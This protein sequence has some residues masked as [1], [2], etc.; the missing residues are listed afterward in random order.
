MATISKDLITGEKPVSEMT[1]I[2]RS[3]YNAHG[4]ELLTHEDACCDTLEKFSGILSI[5]FMNIRSSSGHY[6]A[7]SLLA[8]QTKMLQLIRLNSDCVE[9]LPL[10]NGFVKAISMSEGPQYQAFFIGAN[11]RHKDVP[12]FCVNPWAEK[13]VVSGE[14]ATVSDA[15]VLEMA[16][17]HSI[18]C[19]YEPE[20]RALVPKESYFP[21]VR[22][23]WRELRDPIRATISEVN[24][25]Q[26]TDSTL[27]TNSASS[28]DEL[29]QDEQTASQSFLEV[30][31][32]VAE[33]IGATPH[34]GPNNV[35]ITKSLKSIQ[36]KIDR[37]T[38]DTG[39]SEAYAVSHIEDGVR[40]TLSF[41][42]P[43]ELKEGVLA[44]AKILEAKGWEFDLTNIWENEFDYSGYLDLDA[45]IR[46]P[47]PSHTDSPHYIMAEIQ[48]HL[49]DFYNGRSDCVVS[50]AHKIYEVIRM[51]PVKGK[52]DVNL[53]FDEL[54]EASRMYFTAALYRATTH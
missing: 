50:R 15:K 7:P 8:I 42:T 26:G 23:L 22:E 52:A 49:D 37:I 44:F 20:I 36:E 1:F 16:I 25:I 54:N 6:L 43:E 48:F 51:I 3:A 10:Y 5:L 34:F 24:H 46:I 21:K 12:Y 39:G 17:A 14:L 35:N 53:S 31:T 41:R 38:T 33:E 13:I 28:K 11:K 27:W 47:I 4:I 29:F 18:P 9:M 40:G 19:R 32:Q 45:K 30:C 2:K